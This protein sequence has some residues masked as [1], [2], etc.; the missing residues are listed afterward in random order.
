M[1]KN[2]QALYLLSV[3]CK[4]W[5]DIKIFDLKRVF[6]L[7][8][9]VF[10]KTRDFYFKLVTSD[11]TKKLLQQNRADVFAVELPKKINLFWLS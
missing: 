2:N 9:H 6:M 11:D 3:L 4:K 1:Q 5:M 7:L 10:L 8:L